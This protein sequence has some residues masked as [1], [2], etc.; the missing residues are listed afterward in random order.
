MI[1]PKKSFLFILSI[2]LIFTLSIEAKSKLPNKL[3]VCADPNNLPFSDKDESGFENKIAELIA[4]D[5]KLDLE[6]TWFPQRMGFIRNTLKTWVE[7]EARY[8]CDL[9]MGVPKK[10]D[11]TSNTKAYYRSSYALIFKK[12]GKL[13]DIKTSQDLIDLSETKKADLQI[14]AFSRTPV[15]DWLMKYDLFYEPKTTIIKIMAGSANTNHQDRL[16]FLL[17]DKF[18]VVFVWGPIAGHFSKLHPKHNFK[19]I[20]LI[21]EGHMKFD[22]DIAMGTRRGNKEWKKVIQNSIDRN[23]KQINKILVSYKVPLKNKI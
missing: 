1:T 13:K 4:K 9:V 5:L 20:P 3:R 22:Y 18:D 8:K 6:Y 16:K 2:V 7:K 19:V 15:I 12:N 17:N 11:M 21:S 10:G 14:A 23:Q